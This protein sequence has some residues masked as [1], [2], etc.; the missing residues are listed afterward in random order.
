MIAARLLVQLGANSAEA[1]ASVR[2]VRPGAIQT[3]DQEAWVHAGQV[4][5][6]LQPSRAPDARRDR[7]RGALL[8]LAVGDAVGTAIEFKPKP[9]YA[10][11]DDMVGGGPFQLKPGQW[12]DDT[13]MALALADSLLADPDFDASDLMNRFVSWRD[14]GTYS[15]AGH[16]FDIGST[17][18]DALS[19]FERTG[20]PVAGSTNPLSAGN[21]A[22]MRLSPVA[23]RYGSDRD[24][25]REVAALQTGPRTGP[26]RP[27]RPRSSSPRCWPTPSQAPVAIGALGPFGLSA[28]R[29]R[30]IAT[31]ASWRGRARDEIFGSGYVVDCL[32]AALWAVSRT[33]S[34]RSAVLM[35]A[36]LGQL[37]VDQHRCPRAGHL[38]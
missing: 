13:A 10:L 27:W 11:I 23:I 6:P 12:T 34:F 33:T 36:N 19:R 2:E 4:A 38:A 25:T 26:R 16:C 14:E 8:G 22:L 35:A 37:L 15:C 3:P 28:L 29:S 20:N 9:D 17:G 1:I 31:V 21:G 5:A 32:T 7:A 30:A 24:R 18:R